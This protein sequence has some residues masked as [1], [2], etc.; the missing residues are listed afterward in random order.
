MIADDNGK[1]ALT[2]VC[3]TLPATGKFMRI[4]GLDIATKTGWAS[5]ADG[6]RSGVVE[7][8]LKRGESPGMRFLRCRAWLNEIHV[9]LGG[10]VD[11]IVYEHT[12]SWWCCDCMLCWAGGRGPGFCCRT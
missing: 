10:L 9:L 8:A 6:C 1:K 11:V 4:V 12:P 3:Q 2:V 5:N 7:F